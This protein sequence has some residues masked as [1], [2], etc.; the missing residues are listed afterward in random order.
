M[1]SLLFKNDIHNILPTTTENS[2]NVLNN[3][4]INNLNDD[5]EYSAT[6]SAFMNNNNYNTATS[7]TN[8]SKMVGGNNYNT[9]TSTTNM[10]KMVGGNN[11]NN[12]ETSELNNDINNLLS[13]LTSESNAQTKNAP[14]NT[15]ENK[16][17][18]MLNQDGGDFSDNITTDKLEQKI[19][20]IVK[21][22]NQEGGTYSDEL[23]TEELEQKIHS[24]IN[25]NKQKG[26][27]SSSDIL[28]VG[29]AA[30]GAAFAYNLLKSDNKPTVT[31]S[32]VSVTKFL[33]YPTQQYVQQPISQPFVQQPIVQPNALQNALQQ[34]AQ[35]NALQNFAQQIAQQQAKQQD[36]LQNFAQQFAQQQFAQ[37]QA[38]QQ[39]KS[40][41]ILSTT[42]QNDSPVQSPTYS[43]TSSMNQSKK[44]DNVFLPSP[45]QQI[46]NPYNNSTTT[47]VTLGVDD[48]L[49]SL[50]KQSQPNLIGGNNDLIGGNN[51][52]LVAFRAIVKN[53]VKKLD[54]KY[55]KALKVAAK[56]Q[57]DVK[58]KQPNITHDK[59]A[60]AADK[61]LNSNLKEYKDF[62]KTL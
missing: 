60:D 35:P 12:S 36:T 21:K 45:H 17:R 25:N 33:N 57:A 50:N 1:S 11:Y 19:Y 40:S 23:K 48:R 9:A 55:N 37:M 6:S 59:L 20:N 34:F 42:S 53:V 2:V 41:N 56:V 44:Y 7:T 8:M 29:L 16:L 62:F 38:K 58:A 49:E 51:P 31:E 43:S 47:S 30:T 26:G 22:N 39:N 4:K 27:Y 13:M 32:E 24:I 10:S 54:I 52:A 3:I 18:N 14:E 61:Q 5:N 28:K 15:L 46:I